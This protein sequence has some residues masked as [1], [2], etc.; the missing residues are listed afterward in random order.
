MSRIVVTRQIPNAGLKILERRHDVAIADPGPGRLHDE[1]AL[2][3]LARDADAMITMLS[4]PV[5]EKVIDALPAPSIIAQYAV[6]YDNIDIDAARRAGVT[7]TNTPG[8]LTD[9]TADFAMALLLAVARRVPAA[10][11]YVREG[12][13]TRWET[14]TLLGT[15][16]SGRTIGILGLGRIGAALA[17]RAIGFGMRVIYH[18][19]SRAN[20]TVERETTAR[21]VSF[22]RLLSESDILSIHAS[23]N[24]DSRGL[25]DAETFAKMKRGAILIN[26][27]RGPIVREADLARA[28]QS[29][30]LGGAGL[31]VF[32]DEPEVHPA[33][34][35]LDNVVVAPHLASATETA[36]HRMSQ[37]CGEAV[38]AFLRGEETIPHRVV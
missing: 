4:D 20:P 28:L 15:E 1:A 2:I 33:L 27:G 3:D 21:Y 22:E 35:N 19:R 16:L 31:D 6:G 30:Q 37:M 13:F 17:R 25:F 32:E 38:D 36:R 8:V 23:L 24:E 14:T 10:D 29:G 26:T 7:V 34:L 18:N 11:A 5:T 12:R 9:A